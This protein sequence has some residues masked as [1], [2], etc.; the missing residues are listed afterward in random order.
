[1]G[2]VLRVLKDEIFSLTTLLFIAIPFALSISNPQT[3][4]TPFETMHESVQSAVQSF[5]VKDIMSFSAKSIPSFSDMNL[6]PV[7][8]GSSYFVGNSRPIFIPRS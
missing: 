1:M 6:K 7:K 8:T 4:K 2:F 5:P 3:Q